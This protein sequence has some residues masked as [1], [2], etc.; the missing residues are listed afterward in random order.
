M[1]IVLT[2]NPETHL[3]VLRNFFKCIKRP[4]TITDEGVYIGGTLIC[5]MDK[6]SHVSTYPLGVDTIEEIQYLSLQWWG[7]DGSYQFVD[8]RNP[9]AL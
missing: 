4:L 2:P 7:Q 9:N 1:D 3:E 6:F 5:G 8:V